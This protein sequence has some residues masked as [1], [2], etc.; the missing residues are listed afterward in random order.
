MAT[1]ASVRREAPVAPGSAEPPAGAI[2]TRRSVVIERIAPELDG[3]RYAVKRV[4]GDDLRVTADIF[5]DG[6][7]LL[8]AAL[9]IRAVDETSWREASMRP[10]DD[11]RWSGHISLTRNRHHVYAIEAWRDAIGSWR[12]GIGKKLDAGV[13]VPNELEE[14]RILLDAALA[15]AHVAH[16]TEDGRVIGDALSQYARARSEE[17]RAAAL[18][19]EP[20]LLAARRHADRAFASRA[21]ELGGLQEFLPFRET[22]EANGMELA[23][24]LAIQAAPARP[25]VTDRPEWFRHSP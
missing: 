11:D 14:G 12:D 25:Y 5:A 6:H 23:L 16:A 21:P 24:D 10:V 22:V 13:A 2:G 17:T 4:V 3:G 15:R 20:V 18:L 19:A 8:D 1:R 7:D 9:L